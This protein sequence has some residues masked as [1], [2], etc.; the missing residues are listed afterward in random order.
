[1]ELLPCPFCGATDGRLIQAFR[2]ATDTFAYW[3]VEC[4]DCACEIASDASQAEA[5]VAWNRRT[6]PANQDES[7]DHPKEQTT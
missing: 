4:L 2:R 3:T 6:P 1:M 7:R 5:D